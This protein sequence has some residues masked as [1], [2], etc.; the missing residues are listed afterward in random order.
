MIDERTRKKIE[1]YI[2]SP[3]DT[4]LRPWCD[5]YVNQNGR[6]RLG[7][8]RGIFMADDGEDLLELVDDRG[9]RI[10]GPW[11]F[12]SFRRTELY[13]NKEDCRNQTHGVCDYWERLR[14]IQEKGES[15]DAES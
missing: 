13:D 2:P 1:A 7:H 14:E 3:R 12:D 6:V 11:E 15:D 5:Y 9:R 10:I 8:V 4:S